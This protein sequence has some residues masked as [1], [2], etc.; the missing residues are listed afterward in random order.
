[1]KVY[2]VAGREGEDL[3]VCATEQAAEAWLELIR[4]LNPLI[5]DEYFS[6]EEHEVVGMPEP[7]PEC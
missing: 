1:M 5:R 4:R 6:M 7:D 2:V 3:T